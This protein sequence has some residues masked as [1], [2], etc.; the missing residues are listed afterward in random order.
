MAKPDRKQTLIRIKTLD[1]QHYARTARY[2]R[3]VES[4]YQSATREYS[5]LVGGIFEPDPSR[6]F[7]FADYPE[8]RKKAAK[9]AAD[10]A[11]SVERVI[12]AGQRSEWIAA[13]Y[14]ANTFMGT[15]INRSK[16]TAAELQQY[17][18]RNMEGLAAFQGRK[19]QG[20]GLSQRVW[21]VTD[22]FTGHVELAL[23][24]AIGDGR[25]AEE[26][27]RDVRGLLKEPNKLFRRVRD[28]YG[29]LQLSKAAAAYHPGRGVYRSS[30]QNAMRL[31]RTEINM[32]YR[33]ADWERW[34]REEFVV[35]FR[36][37]LSN[38]HTIKNSKG[39]LEPLTDIC[40]ELAGDYPKTFK[41]VGW[42]PNCRCVITPILKD[43]EEMHKDRRARLEAIMNDEE[44][45]AQPSAKEVNNVPEAFSR[46]IE[47]IA[48]QSKG[49]KSQPYWIRDN[50]K[51]GTIAGGLSASVPH[52]KPVGGTPDKPNLPPQPCTEFDAWIDDLKQQA[53]ALGLDVSRL[54]PLR[55]AGER[56]PLKAEVDRLRRQADDRAAEWLAA[57]LELRNFAKGCKG[58][59]SSFSSKYAK[60]AKANGYDL[61][62]YYETCIQKLKKALADAQ[63]EWNKIQEEERKRKEKEAA[64]QG[65][66][67][68]KQ[69]KKELAAIQ[70]A[71]NKI[72]PELQKLSPSRAS[73]LEYAIYGV[74]MAL[75]GGDPKEISTRLAE[76]QRWLFTFQNPNMPRDLHPGGSYL[77]KH[78]DDYEFS[79]D[80]FRL[81][82]KQPNL[83]ITE[84]SKKGSYETNFGMKVVLDN[85]TRNQ[86]SQY[87]RRAVVYHE[88]GHAIGDQRGLIY[89]Q[90]LRDLRDKQR[91]RLRQREK[92]YYWETEGK[93]SYDPKTGQ[94]SYTTQRVK[95]EVNQM[96]ILTLSHKIATIY[97]KILTKKADD[98]IFKRYGLTQKDAR[99]QITGLMDTLRSLVNRSDVGWGH[100]VEYFKKG[101]HPEHEYL[102]HCF[103]NAF[104]GNTCFRLLMPVE[105]QEMIDYIKTLKEP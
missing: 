82:S 39:E 38:N 45:K 59:P 5:K 101:T 22:Q 103:E 93:S 97:N 58:A 33:T 9:I 27:S 17:E 36:I 95:K 60:I 7:S 41:F 18:D 24:V 21:K 100:T 3:Q 88:F 85:G 77:K 61:K 57:N 11:E 63:A 44:Y 16:L 89:S 1:R 14:R 66:D 87:H 69:A 46:F 56:A 42:H 68:I 23:D 13:T 25:S 51:G 72:L 65:R 75:R 70:K 94:Y 53:Y 73:T 49:W 102:A 54:D 83:V 98:P 74:E 62:R 104:L 19:V 32:A 6:P 64:K 55:A 37:G 47:T 50:F 10:L 15:V 35:G 52:T 105:Y 43:P 78:G 48:D 86:E 26:L 90:E 40:D 80:F 84:N 81:L 91:D 96:R 31:A 12:E 2:A 29:N 76:A 34:Q 99:E 4:L 92:S 79:T 8:T 30:Y 20:L 28:K 71:A 67:V